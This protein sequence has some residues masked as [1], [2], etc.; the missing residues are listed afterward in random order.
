MNVSLDA[1]TI[2]LSAESLSKIKLDPTFLKKLDEL[3]Q[4]SNKIRKKTLY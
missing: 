3:E 4:K 1:N 2:K